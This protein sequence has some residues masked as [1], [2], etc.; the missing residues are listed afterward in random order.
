ML[1]AP[2]ASG[3]PSAEHRT[4]LGSSNTAHG[5][6]RSLFLAVISQA[7]EDLFVTPDSQ[8]TSSKTAAAAGRAR[9]EAEL[10][11]L[12]ERGEWAKSRATICALAGVDPDALRDEC[13]RR[14][15][16]ATS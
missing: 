9:H 7:V 10:F 2:T 6:N 3:T 13:W 14:Y 11:L 5:A 4:S 16:R 12:A 1:E 15:E 8:L